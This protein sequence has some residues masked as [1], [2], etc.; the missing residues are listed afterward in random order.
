MTLKGTWTIWRSHDHPFDKV[1]QIEV[2]ANTR[3]T[4]TMIFYEDEDP[5]VFLG[6]GLLS[7]R[8]ASGM[9]RYFPLA[10]IREARWEP[11]E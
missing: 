8:Y 10:S 6:D 7:V 5:L 9:E 4:D 1:E 2:Q 11:S 3:E